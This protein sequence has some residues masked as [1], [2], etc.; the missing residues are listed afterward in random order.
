MKRDVLGRLILVAGI[1]FCVF[2]MSSAFAKSIAIYPKYMAATLDSVVNKDSNSALIVLH[3]TQADAKE[4]CERDPAG[5][6]T[7]NGGKLTVKQCTDKYTRLAKSYQIAVDCTRGVVQSSEF[8]YT[9]TNRRNG[10]GEK[11]WVDGK[12]GELLPMDN[13]LTVE[14]FKMAC[15]SASHT[16]AVTV[17]VAMNPLAGTKWSNS[18]ELCSG[19]S[20]TFDDSYIIFKPKMIE[21][22]ESECNIVSTFEQA[23]GYT[24]YVT[25]CSSEGEHNIKVTY[26]A[27]QTSATNL[28]VKTLRGEPR[29][30][31]RCH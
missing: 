4:Y 3:N 22:Y 17:P 19:K 9:M 21:E 29:N 6:T 28:S 5:E 25:K 16:A 1:G 24:K 15:P 23:D 11:V 30:L 14:K 7:T 13:T 20:G 12:D 18:E 10:Y 2:G 8:R 27:K 26:F 31:V